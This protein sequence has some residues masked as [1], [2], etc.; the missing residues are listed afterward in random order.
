MA[1][2]TLYV[3][4]QGTATWVRAAAAATRMGVSL[5]T[6]VE[7]AIAMEV[8]ARL[9]YDTKRDNERRIIGLCRQSGN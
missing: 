2:R 7:L 3:S 8:A 6:F 9:G 1:T 4:K 5:S